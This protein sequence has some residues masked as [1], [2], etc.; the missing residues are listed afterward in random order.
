V[1]PAWIAALSSALDPARALA[2]AKRLGLPTRGRA[3][4]RKQ[5]A[6]RQDDGPLGDAEFKVVGDGDETML[7]VGGKIRLRATREG[8][9][10]EIIEHVRAALRAAGGT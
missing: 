3:P 4:A 10:Y 8:L 7:V 9:Y 6:A 2:L 1:T 5:A